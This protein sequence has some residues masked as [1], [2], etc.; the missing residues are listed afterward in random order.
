MGTLSG[1]ASTEGEVRSQKRG[2]LWLRAPANSFSDALEPGWSGD[3]VAEATIKV[4]ALQHECA[5]VIRVRHQHVRCLG[6]AAR[7][8]L[9]RHG[10]SREARGRVIRTASRS[11]RKRCPGSRSAAMATA[12]PEIEHAWAAQ[13]GWPRPR[14]RR[15]SKERPEPALSSRRGRLGATGARQSRALAI[16][17]SWACARKPPAPQ[18]RGPPWGARHDNWTGVRDAGL[19]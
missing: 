1:L 3:A 10:R 2:G 15:R 9:R 19:P 8:E 7:G 4:L 6:S 12:D 16:N 11:R 5:L 13:P 14:W 17:K 18:A